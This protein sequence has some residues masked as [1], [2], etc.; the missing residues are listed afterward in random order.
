MSFS[1]PKKLLQRFR[2]IGIAEGIS[3]LILLLIAMP[4]KYFLKIPEAVKV[5]G[6]MHGALFIAYIYFGIEVTLAFKKNF[7][8]CCKALAA[9]FIPLGTF[10][11]DKQLKKEEM[12]LQ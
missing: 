12:A 10:L 8:W 7:V 1:A 4:M 11:T 2:I 3:F 6:W 5:V 9:A